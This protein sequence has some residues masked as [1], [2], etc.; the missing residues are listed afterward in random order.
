M[1]AAFTGPTLVEP[2]FTHPSLQIAAPRSG[3]CTPLTRAAIGFVIVGEVTALTLIGFLMAIVV[4]G[5]LARD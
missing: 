3:G 1:T 4:L 5:L 2:A